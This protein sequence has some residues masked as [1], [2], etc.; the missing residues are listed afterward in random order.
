MEKTNCYCCKK[1][2]LSA[3]EYLNQKYGE[4]I[5]NVKNTSNTSNKSKTSKHNAV[6]FAYF[7]YIEDSTIYLMYIPDNNETELNFDSYIPSL[8]MVEIVEGSYD[9]KCFEDKISIK[10]SVY[11]LCISNETYYFKPI[12]IDQYIDYVQ[13]NNI[14][15]NFNTLETNKDDVDENDSDDHDSDDD[16][17]DDEFQNQVDSDD[18][19]DDEDEDDEDEDE[20]EDDYDDIEDDDEDIKKKILKMI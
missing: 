18:N 2:D 16:D 5:N 17:E 4:K 20:D 1:K 13:R 9:I 14:D 6:V 12:N 19:E 15:D 8:N 3:I 11:A 7:D 10:G